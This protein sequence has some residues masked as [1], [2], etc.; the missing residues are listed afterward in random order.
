MSRYVKNAI[1]RRPLSLTDM[2]YLGV[3]RGYNLFQQK[4]CQGYSAIKASDRNDRIDGKG[5]M[6]EITEWVNARTFLSSAEKP[7]VKA[8]HAV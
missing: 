5:S 3:R 8:A 2:E 6:A 1:V 4:D 7:P